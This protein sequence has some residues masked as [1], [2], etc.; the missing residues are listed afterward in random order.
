M[1]VIQPAAIA[2][3]P[4]TQCLTD[5]SQGGPLVN[6]NKSTL[7]VGKTNFNNPVAQFYNIGGGCGSANFLIYK[8]NSSHTSRGLLDNSVLI[9]QLT[10]NNLDTLR[11]D[12][13]Y[14]FDPASPYSVITDDAYKYLQFVFIDDAGNKA[15]T[16]AIRVKPADYAIPS[17]ATITASIARPDGI[18]PMYNSNQTGLVSS[19]DVTT[20]YD[21]FDCGVA[22]SASANAAFA[23]ST[24]T[25]K[26][27]AVGA[28]TRVAQ[29]QGY[30]SA[31]SNHVFLVRWNFT[32]TFSTAPQTFYASAFTSPTFAVT[33]VSKSTTY[34]GGGETITVRGT[35]L[36]YAVVR[37]RG[38]I[39]YGSEL[40]NESS[41]SLTFFVPNSRP[42]T[43]ASFSIIT[44]GL[45]GQIDLSP[46]TLTRA[47]TS[48]LT[49]LSLSSGS[50][51][52]TFSS[53]QLTY[54]AAVSASTSSITVT[55]TFNGY[56]ESVTVNSNPVLTGSA[57]SSISLSVG[58]NVIT[59]VGT[60][61]NSSTTTYTINVTRPLPPMIDTATVTSA[62]ATIGQ[63]ASI[64]LAWGTISNT[65]SYTVKIY[66]AAGTSLLR[67]ITGTTGTSLSITTSNF[68]GLVSGSIYQ[69]TVTAVANGTDYTSTGE[70]ARVKGATGTPTITGN[71]FEGNQVTAVSTSLPTGGTYAY[72]WLG[73]TDANNLTAI[74]SGAT[75]STYTP[76]ASDRSYTSQMY[77]AA[78]VSATVGG[79]SYTF[80]SAANP[81]YTYP[82][83]TGGSV[84]SN[85]SGT[86]TPGK[87]TA[88]T[89]VIGHPWQIMGTPWPVLTYQWYI[90]ENT[91]ATSTPA[92]SCST[93]PNG[94]G[95]STHEGGT[96]D[97]DL[98]GYNFSYVA[99]T[100]AIGKYLT[101]TAY[102]TNAAS[103]IT[104]VPFTLVQSRTQ[105]SGVINSAPGTSGNPDIT[106]VASVG[107]KLTAAT[108]TYVGSPTGRISYQWLSSDSE[109]GT[110]N[111][112]TNA[113]ATTYTPVSGDLNQWIKVVVTATNPAGATTTATSSAAM[114]IAQA[115]VLPNSTSIAVIG[116]TKATQV[117]TATASGTTGY[118][119]NFS[120]IYKWYACNSAGNSC[121]LISTSSSSSSTTN[122]YTL[123]N[124]EIGKYIKVGVLVT[125]SAGTATEVKSSITNQV[126][127]YYALGDTGPGGGVIYY[128]SPA[129]FTETGATCN[130][131]CHYLE[132]AT[133]IE[134]PGAWAGSNWRVKPTFAALGKGLS[135]TTAMRT[136]NND[137]NPYLPSAAAIEAY[138]YA[139]ND[140]SAHQWFIGSNDEMS[141]LVTYFQTR[142]YVAAGFKPTYYFTSTEGT[143]VDAGQYVQVGGVSLNLGT[144]NWVL[145][146]SGN[147][148][149]PIRAI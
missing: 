77:L 69:F 53:G 14:S 86:Y 110:Y 50:L 8:S 62:S 23:A 84:T 93:A 68:P 112:I 104:T 74:S 4:T 26:N 67:T 29:D 123:T 51:S 45:G 48:T 11:A 59:V 148:F 118:P 102:L 88:G 111:P 5:D 97:S 6:L 22:G 12:D 3:P 119:N 32:D 25:Q 143:L 134:L 116:T 9:S 70:S 137:P 17:G 52:P 100:E 30:G 103:V 54:T 135:N 124:S 60:A 82:N 122:S 20:T 131:S 21:W 107:K 40:T 147:W 16:T 10:T 113:R 7:Q 109:S 94:A 58:A 55:P 146:N 34:V 27:T 47:T 39:I 95:T 128:Y 141:E 1:S 145:K 64:D 125:S 83:A 120:Y 42:D 72:Q 91:A 98:G 28:C 149:R 75:S 66:D 92:S 99:P 44:A 129:A 101:F 56:G 18:H 73:G 121:S 43:T 105:N 136:R 96:S 57:S 117:L 144:F 24:K 37:W 127:A 114:Q 19:G 76:K 65:T 35:G 140:G 31:A 15:V 139:A 49:N 61:E 80:T 87:Y 46:I 142:D 89:T 126:A 41:T 78:R 106:G 132:Y 79:N 138:N 90:C 13:D 71:V 81:V 2:T 85:T 130:T 108:V 115:Y 33:S 133:G 63:S 38:A 36:D